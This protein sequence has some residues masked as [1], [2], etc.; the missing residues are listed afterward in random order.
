MGILSLHLLGQCFERCSGGTCRMGKSRTSL[1][2]MLALLLSMLYHVSGQQLPSNF[3]VAPGVPAPA[4]APAAAHWQLKVAGFAPRL[5]VHKLGCT[6]CWRMN[7]ACILQDESNTFWVCA[8][9]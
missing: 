5:P 6:T 9:A 4:G 8:Q 2:G 1:K 7:S 3:Q